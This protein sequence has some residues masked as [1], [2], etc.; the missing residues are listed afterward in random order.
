MT[1]SALPWHLLCMSLSKSFWDN[2]FPSEG[3]QD[4]VVSFEPILSSIL[5]LHLWHPTQS[6]KPK[7]T[8]LTTMTKVL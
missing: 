8:V 7:F 3:G 4:K 2:P 6:P 5:L 1:V